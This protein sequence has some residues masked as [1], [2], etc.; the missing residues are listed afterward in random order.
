MEAAPD[1]NYVTVD[2]IE[3]GD[4]KL[5]VINAYSIKQKKAFKI[6]HFEKNFRKIEIMHCKMYFN[7]RV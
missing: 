2:F 5:N 4:Q 6:S 1:K 3:F 7:L